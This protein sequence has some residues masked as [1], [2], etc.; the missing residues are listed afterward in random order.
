MQKRPNPQ[1]PVFSP[2]SSM[3][4][5]WLARGGRHS[6]LKAN[7][8]CNTIGWLFSFIDADIFCNQ[9]LNESCTTFDCSVLRLLP[10]VRHVP[11]ATPPSPQPLKSSSPCSSH[12]SMTTGCQDNR[13]QH[14]TSMFLRAVLHISNTNRFLTSFYII[15][16]HTQFT[17]AAGKL[18]LHALHS[19][20][21]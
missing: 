9:Y 15:V 2:F 13:T 14:S 7:N 12:P 5:W 21:T 4:E 18:T 8:F 11:L 10:V 6:T 19:S 1:P 3:D 16:T 20:V 17:F